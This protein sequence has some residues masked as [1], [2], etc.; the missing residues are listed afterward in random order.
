MHAATR[1]S[2]LLTT[3]STGLWSYSL[4]LSKF[5]IGFFGLID[6]YH[7]TYFLALGLLS[8][9]SF[10]LWLS[11]E[12][13]GKLLCLQVCL[14]IVM[15]WLTP[16]LFGANP[17]STVW[18]YA[19]YF[20]NSD[21][22][23]QTGH[24]N[25]NLSFDIYS[26]W[27]MANWP[28]AFLFESALM[29]VTGFNTADFTALYGPLF[30]QFLILPPLY[31]FFK[32]TIS[33]PNHC[34]AACWFFFLANWTAQLYFC[35]QGIGV[36]LLITLLALFSRTAFWQNEGTSVGQQFS[37]IL[38][39]ASL[40]ITHVLTSLVAFLSIGALWVTRLVKGANLTI[41]AG[42]LVAFWSIY[43][44]TTQLQV[45][46]PGFIERAFRLDLVFQLSALGA[47]GTAS[48]SLLGVAYIRYIFTAIIFFIGLIGFLIS[49][50][51]KDKADFPMLSLFIPAAFV[52][53]SMFYGYEFWQRVFLFSLAPVSYFAVKMLRA[54]ISAGVLCSLLLVLLP[55]N[56]ISHYGYAATD[57]E[58]PAERAYWHFAAENSP[59]GDVFGG[60]RIYYP[61]FTYSKFYLDK[62]AWKDG[63]F[64][65]NDPSNS[66]AQYVHVGATDRASFE[67]YLNDS[68][69]V[70]RLQTALE[71]SPAYSLIYANPSVNLYFHQY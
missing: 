23:A 31:I 53:F 2:L 20:P 57:Y 47:A 18:T 6:S 37:I 32:N 41:L 45:S 69:S 34:W 35:P 52:L 60:T 59:P 55:L 26:L 27:T 48:Q 54:N 11:Q 62:A 65:L 22:I 5:A 66:R 7:Y 14:F 42:V 8:I 15:L 56:I 28:G 25:A 64:V 46:L 30:T 70:P 4:W 39:L 50:K 3:A 17:V 67:F 9:S 68:S 44:A 43:G 13:H 29:K 63:V 33:H 71:E 38:T 51:F 1:I 24:F 49:I 58:P 19:I 36:F 61:D 10:I 16:V 21:V 40:T 12:E